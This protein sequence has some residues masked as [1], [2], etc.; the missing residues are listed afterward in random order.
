MIHRV[1]T[2]GMVSDQLVV[3][4][5]LFEQGRVDAARSRLLGA[6]S[7]GMDALSSEQDVRVALK[8][9]RRLGFSTDEPDEWAAFPDPLTI[10]RAGGP[11]LAWTAD[12]DVAESLA[13]RYE[14]SSIRTR[15]IAKADV[16]AYIAGRGESEVIVEPGKV[17]RGKA[18]FMG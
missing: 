10:H 17:S 6:W 13:R 1:R 3:A 18:R 2:R 11:G 5:R 4:Y 7:A 14:L 9:L 15:T 12:R 16:L 8:L